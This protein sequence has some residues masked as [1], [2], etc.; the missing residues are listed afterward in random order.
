[1]AIMCKNYEKGAEITQCLIGKSFT[2]F[3]C[4]ILSWLM[5]TYFIRKIQM[6][7]LENF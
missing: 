2:S 1:M 3:L 7:T 6:A 4:N 5:F